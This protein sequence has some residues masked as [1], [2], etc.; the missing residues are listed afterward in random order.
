MRTSGLRGRFG[1]D[2]FL[3]QPFGHIFVGRGII[4]AEVEELIALCYQR[5]P[6]F[7]KHSFDLSDVLQDNCTGKIVGAAGRQHIIE[8][9]RWRCIVKL[10]HDKAH[11][12]RQSAAVFPFCAVVKL[13]K[14]LHIHHGNKVI[15][16]GVVDR[17]ADENSAFLL[18]ERC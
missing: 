2:R 12:T 6:L 18:T 15:E 1:E 11:M 3:T 10:V 16:T 7:F 8:T 9:I 5:F 14:S 13:L 17:R 4:A